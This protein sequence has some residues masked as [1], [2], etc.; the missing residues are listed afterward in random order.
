MA[1]GGLNSPLKPYSSADLLDNTTGFALNGFNLK[2]DYIIIKQSKLNF[3]LG[4]HYFENTFDVKNVEEQN[5]KI[6]NLKTKYISIKP[7][8]GIGLGLGVMYYL[9]PLNK[10]FKAFSKIT[11][12]QLY[13]NSPE[14]SIQD[15]NQYARV[16]S[17]NASSIFWSLGGG[18]E[19]A[20]TPQLSVVGFV[21][22]FYAKVDFGNL[23]LR[24]AFGQ[25]VTYV[26]QKINEQTLSMLN[27]N[28]GLSYKFYQY[29]NN[30]KI[31]K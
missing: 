3:S 19:Y 27:I 2:L 26:S 30:F 23:K 28:I 29:Q 13:V 15:T 18:M 31:K 14:Y 8:S 10:K 5:N 6:Y 25:T 1:L 7:Y 24:N 17:N 20:L 16:L 12:G 9:T 21:E 4:L 11:L 22:Y